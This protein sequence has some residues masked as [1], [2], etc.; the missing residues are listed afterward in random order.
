MKKLRMQKLIRIKIS[1][2]QSA[3]TYPCQPITFIVNL[4]VTFIAY[5]I[6]CKLQFD[7]M[8]LQLLIITK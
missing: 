3:L 6:D 8:K 1:L 2:L 4:S 5:N 7:I